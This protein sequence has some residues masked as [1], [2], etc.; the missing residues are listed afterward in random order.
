MEAPEGSG[1]ATP[2]PRSIAFTFAYVNRCYVMCVCLYMAASMRPQ[3]LVTHCLWKRGYVN[4]LILGTAFH[5]TL[6][7]TIACPCYNNVT[8]IKWYIY[9][10]ATLKGDIVHQ[11]TTEGTS[12]YKTPF[13]GANGLLV[14]EG[15]VLKTILWLCLLLNYQRSSSGCLSSTMISMDQRGSTSINNRQVSTTDTYQQPTSIN[16]QHGHP[17]YAFIYFYYI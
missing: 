8:S 10:Q 5:C 1:S 2:K 3:M 17:F 16:N 9:I 12:Q 14:P 15:S 6:H 4:K 11:S 7:L 13:H